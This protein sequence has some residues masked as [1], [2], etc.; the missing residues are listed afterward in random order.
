MAK[1]RAKMTYSHVNYS[2]FKDAAKKLLMTEA[3][4]GVGL[5]YSD[6]AF[7]LWRKSGL[8]PK[9]AG[10]ACECLL[11]RNRLTEDAPEPSYLFILR[12]PHKHSLALQSFTAA[13][14]ISRTL[15][16]DPSEG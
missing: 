11:R 9:V 6:S 4:L 2:V 8:V 15:I 13:L 5:G 7:R 16:E 10:L 14:G 12:V 3:Q 1:A